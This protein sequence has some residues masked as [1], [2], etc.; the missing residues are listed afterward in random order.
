[1]GSTTEW[2]DLFMGIRQSEIEFIFKSSS[3]ALMPIEAESVPE[4]N[5]WVYVGLGS[6]FRGD[7]SA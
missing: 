1:M 2:A 3:D 5:H 6:R 4:Q 7:I